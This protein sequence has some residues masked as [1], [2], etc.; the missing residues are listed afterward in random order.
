MEQSLI[1]KYFTEITKIPRPSHFN[2][3]IVPWLLKKIKS[4]GYKVSVDK[5]GNIFARIPATEGR[6]KQKAVLLQAHIDMVPVA[7]DGYKHD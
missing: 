1:F 6:E 5:Y 2:D 4:F 3:K 7:S